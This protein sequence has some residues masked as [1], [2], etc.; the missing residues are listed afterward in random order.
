MSTILKIIALQ[1]L[2][3]EALTLVGNLKRREAKK[4]KRKHHD[5]MD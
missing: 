5:A 1:E 2:T 4:D 3:F